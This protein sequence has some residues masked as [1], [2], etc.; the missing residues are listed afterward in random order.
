M[1]SKNILVISPHPDDLEIAMSGTVAKLIKEGHTVVSVVVTDGSGSTRS[2]NMSTSE[3]VKIRKSEVDASSEILG[4]K[5]LECFRLS[6]V[7]SEANRKKLENMLSACFEKYNPVEIYIPHPEI[8]KHPTHKIVA[9]TSIRILEG[10]VEKGSEPRIWCYEVWTPFE[11]YDRI[12][13]ITDFVEIK[14]KAINTHESQLAYKDYT[15]GVLG[16]NRY[17][18]VFNDVYEFIDNS[19]AEVFIKYKES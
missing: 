4:I 14:S 17:R 7:K 6:E 1:N 13:D 8:D 12:E 10:L 3:L 2:N 5:N 16:L 19:Y 9:S 11:Q 18:A 15:A